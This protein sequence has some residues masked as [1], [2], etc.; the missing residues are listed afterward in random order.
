M[1]LPQLFEVTVKNLNNVLQ[2]WTSI[3]N[4]NGQSNVSFL[5]LKILFNSCS[6]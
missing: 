3:K 1:E 5:I 2:K 6:M 4:F